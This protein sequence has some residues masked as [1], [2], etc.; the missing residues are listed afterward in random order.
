MLPSSI[1]EAISK[2]SP[3]AQEVIQ[4][5]ISYY[6]SELAKRDLKI[7]ELEDRLSKNSRNSSKAPSSDPPFKERLKARRQ[8][9]GRKP[10]GQKG[11]KGSTLKMV[12]A[13]DKTEVHELLSCPDC[14][15]CL[16]D[17][18]VLGY[19]L[20]QVFDT[21]P[22]EM[23]VVEHQSEQ[24]HCSGCQKEVSAAFPLGVSSSVQY[25]PNLRTLLSYWQNYQMLP[26]ARTVEMVEDLTGHKLSAGTL[27][28][29]QNKVYDSLEDFESRLIE[30][31]CKEKLAHFDETGAKMI[32]SLAE[33]NL[34]ML[35]VKLKVSGCFRSMKGA[36][37]F[38]R[39][40]SFIVTARMQGLTAF[41]ALKEL[42][43]N[44]R[45]TQDRLILGQ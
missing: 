30:L 21:A 11:H 23:E 36:Q 29:T 7:K 38:M 10:G 25:G 16:A 32:R 15:E 14:G 20:R 37:H 8:K 27:Y 31:L 44:P 6:E 26:Y 45:D 22:I 9:S 1:Q 33:R 24:K 40:R 2:L 43:V 41:Q 18:P 17:T 42:F 35:K 19:D 12:A 28:N 5:L 4:I 34:R 39:I 3:E 13:P